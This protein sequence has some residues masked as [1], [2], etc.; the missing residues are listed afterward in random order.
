M[1]SSC[2]PGSGRAESPS[3]EP[4]PRTTCTGRKRTEVFTADAIAPIH[5]A[6]GG[7]HREVDRVATAALR[8][9]AQRKKKL[10]ERD[11]LAHVLE[12]SSEA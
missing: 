7:A 9:A 1:G 6:A 12:A 4:W 10:V 2:G 8:V 5:E 3:T 11:T